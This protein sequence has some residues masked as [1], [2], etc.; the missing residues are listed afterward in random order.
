[1]VRSKGRGL[2]DGGEGGGEVDFA[3]VDGAA[4]DDAPGTGGFGGEDVG[5]VADAAGGDDGELGG[6][7]EFGGAG[8][9]G[10]GEHS[11]DGD[12]G[13]EEGGE[14]P[15]GDFAG[16]FDGG[17]AGGAGP[18]AGGDDAVAGV[19]GEDEF[20]FVFGS[21]DQA[22]EP[23]PVF[24]GGGADDD[25]GGAGGEEGVDIGLGADAAADLDFEFDGF[26]DGADECG[27][28]DLAGFGAV[29][30]DEVHVGCAGGGEGLGGVDGVDVVV[31]LL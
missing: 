24:E 25:S 18:S 23:G 16:E 31:G 20:V 27:L 14:G 8:E 12:V 2:S 3:F 13:V 19:E 28:L 11:V 7:R 9:V 6:A 26:D 1:M 5:V 30:V 4:D 29:E 22:G 10:A 17:L 21:G 15:V